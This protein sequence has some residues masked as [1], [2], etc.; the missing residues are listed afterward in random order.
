M[1]KDNKPESFFNDESVNKDKLFVDIPSQENSPYQDKI[2]N[3]YDPM[4]EIYLRGRAFRSMAGG[5]IPWPVLIS[6]WIL[7][8]GL[9][10]LV[11]IVAITSQSFGNLM[12]LVTTMIPLLIVWRGTSAK[13]SSRKYR[14][15]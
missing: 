8:G 14:N 3:G 9:N 11:I 2:P 7:F 4:G 5:S 6:G 15:R 13:L 12:L 1:N 10:L